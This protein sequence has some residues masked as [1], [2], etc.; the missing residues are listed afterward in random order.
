MFAHSDVQAG[1]APVEPDPRPADPL[2][3]VV[4]A[5]DIEPGSS[6]VVPSDSDGDQPLG[7]PDT[8]ADGDKE[9]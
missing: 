7:D 5:Q 3:P 1:L 2:A 9:N 8:P 4:A 6:P